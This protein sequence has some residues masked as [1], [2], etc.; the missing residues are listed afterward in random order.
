M[1]C[2]GDAVWISVM[3]ISVV[4][5]FK[6]EAAF[7]RPCLESLARQTERDFEVVAVNDG[8]TD[9]SC[10][11]LAGFEGRLPKVTLLH[12][13][14][15]GLVPALNLGLSRATGDF[16]ARADGEDRKSVV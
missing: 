7:L 4:L 8:S 10:E 1:E 12:T 14:G 6:N 15:H 11:I 3:R 5:P 2:A 16:V 13:G 9:E